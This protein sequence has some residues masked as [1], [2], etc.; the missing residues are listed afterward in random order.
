M[1]FS[2]KYSNVLFSFKDFKNNLCLK[3]VL[4]INCYNINK[5]NI[6]ITGATGFIGKI[7]SAYL[8]KVEKHRVVSLDRSMFH[9]G[10][11]ARLVQV[12]SETDVVINLAGASINRRWTQRYKKELYQSRVGVT[13]QLVRALEVAQPKPKLLISVSAVAYYPNFGRF[14]EDSYVCGEGFLSELCYDWEKEANKCPSSVR[15]VIARL[16]IVI[17]PNGGFLKQ[18]L[19]PIKMIKLASVISPGNQPFPWISI[20]DLCNAFNFF[21]ENE[22]TR[23]TYNL[24]IPSTTIHSRFVHALAKVYRAWFIMVIPEFLI[25]LIFG[26]AASFMTTGQYVRPKRLLEAGFKFSVSNL[27][28]L[29]ET[30]RS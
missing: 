29:M 28:E 5:M 6:A 9:E 11:S 23:G 20:N 27:E 19:R 15:L 12:L 22:T 30:I 24:V 17:S 14:D 2:Y 21:I 18:L 3:S 7:L 10:M 25:K 1:R 16:G 8:R 13:Q 26:E 4:I